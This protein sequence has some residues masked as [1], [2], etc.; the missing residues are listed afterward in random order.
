MV[1]AGALESVCVV[2][3]AACDDNAHPEAATM[4][5]AAGIAALTPVIRSF[6]GSARSVSVPQRPASA[7]DAPSPSAQLLHVRCLGRFSVAVNGQD[8]DL[9]GLRP[10]ARA[11][12]KMLAIHTGSAV[13][14]ETIVDAL[15][16]DGAA[17]AG[18][19]NLQVAVSAIR[20]TLA[21]AGV[22]DEFGVQRHGEAYRLTLPGTEA[23]DLG[24]FLDAAA[25]A[26]AAAARDDHHGAAL[27]AVH[28]LDLYGGEL[29]SEDG[30]LD[31]IVT[32]RAWVSGVRESIAAIL[33]AEHVRNGQFKEAIEVC[34]ATIVERPYADELWR[35]LVGAHR[36]RGDLAAAGK[37]QSR[38]E[39]VLAELVG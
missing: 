26:K 3:L 34:E 18:I 20:K 21:N 22:P 6:V 36:E 13:H 17:D 5:R 12:F 35:T 39:H 8:L 28:A 15:W 24:Q 14:R 16:P 38:Y 23:S 37:A 2:A 7:L 19:H 4:A 11:L 33:A 25:A 32:Q 1:D 31:W 29:L 30:P 27:S 10:R 9:E